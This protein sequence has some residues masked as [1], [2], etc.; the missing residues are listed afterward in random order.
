MAL[1]AVSFFYGASFLPQQWGVEDLSPFGFL[2][3]RYAI[4]G[5]IAV[6][7][8]LRL[9]W[10]TSGRG[11]HEIHGVHRWRGLLIAGLLVAALTT[12]GYLAQLGGLRFTTTSNSAFI[13]GLYAVFVPVFEIFIY[14]R[15]PPGAVLIAIGVAIL[16]LFFLTGVS[17][18]FNRGDALTLITAVTWGLWI[19]IAGLLGRRF[20]VF[21]LATFVFVFSALTSALLCLI[22]GFGRLTLAAV[23]WAVVLGLGSVMFDSMNLWAQTRVEPSRAGVIMLV[24]PVVAAALGYIVGE[25]IGLWGAFGALLMLSAIVLV[26]LRPGSADNRE[27]PGESRI[28][29]TD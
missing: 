17:G 7:F 28:E 24:E 22:L 29:V 1:I 5:V 15:R 6:P 3:V 16:G 12:I 2:A 8:A 21:G 4:A 14:R 26:E 23:G 9:G 25:R 13:T 10:R 18:A 27:V 19:A 20:P 11:A